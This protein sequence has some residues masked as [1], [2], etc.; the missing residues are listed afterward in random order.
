M[1][2]NL[3]MKTTR[4]IVLFAIFGLALAACSSGKATAQATPIPTVLADPS[5]VAT[6]RLEPVRYID[7]APDTSGLVSEVL[8]KEGDSVTAGQVLARIQNSQAQTLEN[9]QAAASQQ[10]TTAYQ[11]LRDAQY[12]LDN[13]DIP[14]EFANQTP[15]EAVSETLDKLNTARAAYEPYRYI[16]F[17]NKFEDF[18]LSNPSAYKFATKRV[19]GD[20]LEAKKRLDDAWA[21]YRKAI[22]WIGLEADLTTA[23]ANLDQAQKNYNSLQDSSF[24]ENTAG[25]RAAL[26]NAEVRAPFAGVITT[27]NLKAGE[28]ASAGQS[29]ATLADTSSW[30]VKTTDLTEINV[31]KISEGQ[32]VTVKLDAIPNVALKGYVLSVGQGFSKNQGDI[33][34]EVT[35]LLTDKQPAMR[36]G[37]TSTV[38]FEK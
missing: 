28:F 32:P 5:V 14:S 19:N 16:Y 25:L 11:T 7:I 21:K 36:W 6:G 18:N 27:L 2:G 23:Q 31:V 17:D 37:M 22:Q 34:Y 10:L 24:A 13:F 3:R 30:V 20:A 1:K 26:A 35:V 33:V 12:K 38:T 15:A 29:V 9:A 8:V 4:I